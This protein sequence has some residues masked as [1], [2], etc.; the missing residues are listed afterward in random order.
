MGQQ[1]TYQLQDWPNYYWDD[2]AFAARLADIH[3]RRGA[4]S[5]AMKT[6]GFAARQE[7]V[8]RVIVEDVTR[9]SEIEG[10]HLD[11]AKVRSSVARRLGIEF[12]GLP[13]PTRDIEGVVE[14]MLDATQ[15]YQAP[16][17]DERIFAWHS[18]LFP[19]ARSG[20]KKIVTGAYRDDKDGPM[21][22][23]SGPIGRERVH[24]EAP[25]AAQVP[26]EMKGFLD[27]FET[28]EMDPVVKAA[29]AHLWF[30]TI[31]P[32][33]DGNGRIGRAIMDMA[34][35][36]ADR[37]KQRFY[38]MTA[39]IHAESNEYYTE[40][41][42]ASKDTLD[43]TPW[44]NWFLQRLDA[45]LQAAESV[46]EI[47]HQKQAFWEAHH[48]DGLNERQTKIINLL[49]DGFNGKLQTA[50]YA[51]LT[52]TSNDTALRDLTDLVDRGILAKVDAGRSTSYILAE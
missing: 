27:W 11:A 21:Q 7:A 28:K 23:V 6:L 8:L 20:M 3:S 5:I 46:L 48:N 18:T 44:I 14:M 4:L 52:K 12:A 24:F 38:S 50:K 40:L 22:V 2:S 25:A 41:Q 51:T 1:Y 49:L 9:S 31:H 30:V 19:T 33:E 16:L 43:I 37:D 36:R 26:S 47:V 45:A 42:R 35:A 13:R 39:Q 34:L 32:M 17:D 15:N 10:E 29:V